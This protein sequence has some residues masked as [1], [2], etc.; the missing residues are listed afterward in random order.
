M[1]TPR[2]KQV[3]DFLLQ[4][5]SEHGRSPTYR[6][7]SDG[8]GAASPHTS[9]DLINR[10]EERGYVRVVRRIGHQGSIILPIIPCKPPPI[11]ACGTLPPIPEGPN[12]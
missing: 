2:Q 6:I 3:F 5:W 12:G 11:A 7:L 4:Y 9:F 10:L 8:I 1:I